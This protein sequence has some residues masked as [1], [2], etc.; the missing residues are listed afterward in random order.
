M[1]TLDFL[2]TSASVPT[3]ERG[4]PAILVSHDGRRFLVDCGEGTQR[5]LIRAGLGFRRIDTVLLTHGHLDHVL[6]LGGLAATFSEWGTQHALT[7]Y[8]GRD[9]LREARRL[10]EGVVLPEAGRALEAHFVPLAPG[11]VLADEALRLTA[12]RVRHRET[13]SFGFVFEGRPRRHFDRTRAAALGLPEST[14][15]QRLAAGEAVRLADGR[16]IAPEAVLGPEE[17]G[18]RLAVIG[19]LETTEGLVEH[20]RGA[21]ALVIEATFAAADAERARAYAHITAAQATALAREARV[22]ALYLTHIS[23]R[24]RGPELEAEARTVFPAARVVADLDRV[25][26][27]HRRGSPHG[28]SESDT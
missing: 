23:A 14:L 18:P 4:L 27:T 8:G 9:A 25:T 5:Q 3:A 6:G 24:Y 12:F 11:P 13:D 22:G 20:V 2:G 28:S 7:V 21:D 1:F 10:L 26:V 16:E 15:R 17:P 19:D